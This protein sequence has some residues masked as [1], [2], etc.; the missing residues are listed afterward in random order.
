MMTLAACVPIVRV[1]TPFSSVALG[2]TRVVAV[3][4]LILM[5]ISIPISFLVVSVVVVTIV[6]FLVGLGIFALFDD[7]IYL[8]L[9]LIF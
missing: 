6:V 9:G 1:P 4:V 7:L 2:F 8:V 3:F 5:P